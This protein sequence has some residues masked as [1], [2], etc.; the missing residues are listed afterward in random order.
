MST[1]KRPP[2]KGYKKVTN[3]KP[4]SSPSPSLMFVPP[5]RSTGGGGGTGIGGGGIA[6]GGP[7]HDSIILKRLEDMTRRMDL[8]QNNQ[9]LNAATQLIQSQ[10]QPPG[11]SQPPLFQPQQYQA[12][13]YQA[14]HQ[15]IQHSHHQP[16]PPVSFQPQPPSFQPMLNSSPRHLELVS[17]LSPLKRIDHD[18]IATRNPLLNRNDIHPMDPSVRLLTFIVPHLLNRKSLI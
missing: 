3:Q 9:N 4:E 10:S 6:I 18:I 15:S 7:S 17:A 13:T 14:N 12:A 1:T 2:V 16:Q 5:M 8:M 11:P